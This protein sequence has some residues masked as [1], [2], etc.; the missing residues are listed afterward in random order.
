MSFES[1]LAIMKNS[2]DLNALFTFSS[3]FTQSQVIA[4]C[5]S[6]WKRVILFMTSSYYG[7][8]FGELTI[9]FGYE[10]LSFKYWWF[11]WEIN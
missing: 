11:S 3:T 8:I 10:P 7:G 2:T 5:T 1:N 6:F 9:S 4:H